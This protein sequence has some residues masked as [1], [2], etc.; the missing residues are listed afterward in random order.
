M[1][2][3]PPLRK[4]EIIDL[5]LSNYCYWLLTA[6]SVTI[7]NIIEILIIFQSE[8]SRLAGVRTPGSIVLKGERAH[9][10]VF[11]AFLAIWRAIYAKFRSFR[12]ILSLEGALSKRLAGKLSY[13]PLQK[14]WQNR[15]KYWYWILTT[16]AV[17]VDNILTCWRVLKTVNVDHM[18]NIALSH[19]V[20]YRTRSCSHAQVRSSVSILSL[21]EPLKGVDMFKWPF[22]ANNWGKCCYM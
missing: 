15:S 11:W 10:R 2:P 8:S 20:G 17:N 16:I 12:T 9:M 21:N 13:N 7:D 14:N 4:Y 18:L 22:E 5:Q 1:Q 19:G 3:P 6:N